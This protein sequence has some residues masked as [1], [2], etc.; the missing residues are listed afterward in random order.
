MTLF[1]PRVVE[2]L[3]LTNFILSSAI[4]ITSFS[5]LAYILV[6][7]LRSGVARAFCA[8]LAC[9]L[10]VYFSDLILFISVDLTAAERWLRFQWVGIAFVPAAYLHFSDA[11]L[12]TTNQ[13]SAWR[14]SATRASYLVSAGFLLAAAFGDS[15]VRDGVLVLHEPR[16]HAGP[17]FG[18]FVLYFFVAV[19]WG[20]ANTIWA[21][22]RCLTSTSRRRMTYLAV[23]FAV[24]GLGVFP[25]LL[26]VSR[27]APSLPEIL[28]LFLIV[29]NLGVGTMLV[30]MAYTVA[31]F[32]ALT[33]DRVVKHRL[34]H[35]LVRGPFTAS[36]VAGVVILI[37][38]VEAFLGLQR[39]LLV[40]VVL[41]AL[42][43][44]LQLFVSLARP[45][46]DLLIFS[47]DRRELVR[48]QRL[49]E[50]LLTTTDLQQFLEN[51]LS[52][53]CDLL[54]VPAAFVVAST[55]R[56][57]HIEAVVGPVE[58]APTRESLEISMSGE[59]PR[60]ALENGPR[61]TLGYWVWPVRSHRGN[62]HSVLGAVAVTA[63]SDRPDL[64]PE[65][66]A[67]VDMLVGQAA[68]A[69]E[70]RRLQ[71]EVFAAVDNIMPELE[72]I[73]RQRSAVRYVDSAT[74]PLDDNLFK[75]A[76]FT[77]LVRDAL[78]HYWGGPKLTHSPLIRLKVVQQALEE[79]EGSPAKALRA[80]LLQA[81]DRLKPNGD[82]RMTAA[83]WL[84][85]NILELKFVQGQR[86][87]EIAIRLAVSESDLYRKQR[88]AIEA[89]AATLA[90]ME[91]Q[92]EVA[93]PGE[94]SAAQ[95]LGPV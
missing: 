15:I 65:E 55:P 69:L 62:G 95:G 71:Q 83:E 60:G 68:K 41:V 89:V 44:L 56:G 75:S 25:Y 8:L 22:R 26:V 5:L 3:A 4:V 76:E 7:N 13:H 48:I 93:P 45:Y 28:W 88:V 92:A 10:V 47:R 37:S 64:S 36:C 40:L 74:L 42:I 20:V 34:I 85:F 17:L 33:P 54:R 84:L 19:G 50:R 59:G 70:D 58:R 18:L 66:I 94:A 63:R 52:A 14:Q 2:A 80:V 49:Y 27:M 1:S 72:A 87:R 12:R 39:D 46:V 61:V 30:V 90:D 79:N 23:S 43:V 78:S 16:L 57:P 21:R 82:R 91:R 53:I 73:Q 81:M 32:G 38:R 9:M 51:T 86:V 67:G 31:Y 24:P 11:L 35:F 6:Y 77:T 29:A